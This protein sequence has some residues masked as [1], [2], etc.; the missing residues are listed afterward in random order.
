MTQ[1][2][3]GGCACGAIRYETDAD[4]IVMLNCHCSDCRKASG[5]GYAAII[6]VR[7]DEV[8]LR[9]EVRFDGVRGSSGKM[10]ERG[11]CPNCGSPVI[12]K[13]ERLANALGIQAGSLD[14]PAL[15]KPSMDL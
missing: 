2:L 12:Q 8:K 13:V 15:Y 11:F 14:D 6:F 4:P 5:S 7:K 1:K 9:G 10:V 3:S